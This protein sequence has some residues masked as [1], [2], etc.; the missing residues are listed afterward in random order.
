MAGKALGVMLCCVVVVS[1]CGLGA[2]G[3]LSA[4][5][6]VGL[7]AKMSVL[8]MSIL[9]WPFIN[10]EISDLFGIGITGLLFPGVF[11]VSGSLE[12]RILN[13]DTVDVLPSISV[14]IAGVGS[15][16]STSATVSIIAEYSIRR[17]LAM[18]AAVSYGSLLAVGVSV[19]LIFYF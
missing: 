5:R 1:F 18:R 8:P 4:D 3:N 7:G 6:G 14:G 10:W 19:S 12:Y 16:V 2:S 9:P 15:V 11:G 13:G 17:S